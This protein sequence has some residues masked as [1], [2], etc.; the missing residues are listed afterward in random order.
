MRT[1]R[2]GQVARRSGRGGGGH[3]SDASRHPSVPRGVS[4]CRSLRRG[5]SVWQLTSTR[6][7]ALRTSISVREAQTQSNSRPRWDLLAV[8]PFPTL[9]PDAEERMVAAIDA[10]RAEGD[11]VGGIIECVATG[12]P[13]GLGSPL[14]D[15]VES[16]IARIAFGVPAVKGIE[17]AL[18]SRPRACAA[19]RTTIPTALTSK[20]QSFSS[21]TTREETSAVSPPGHPSSSA[22]PSSPHPLSHASRTRLTSP[23][24]R[25]QSFRSVDGTIRA[26]PLA[27]CPLPRRSWPSHC[28]I[29]GL[30]HT[31]RNHVRLCGAA[32][33]SA[34]RAKMGDERQLLRASR[35]PPCVPQIRTVTLGLKLTPRLVRDAARHP[36]RVA[37]CRHDHVAQAPI[38]LQVTGGFF[39]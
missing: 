29:A 17:L 9:C 37:F 33:E 16:A 34:S 12:L 7:P 11:S 19:A 22:W 28:L 5:E 30:R 15:G 2:T 4:R 26:S 14:F 10:A 6:L 38:D 13:A 21:R 1:H 27:P 20:A 25:R 36:E 32:S 39:T 31:W 18:A 24:I 23:P 35:L 3:F 8:R